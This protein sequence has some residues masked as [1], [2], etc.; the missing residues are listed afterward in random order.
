MN[1]NE[2]PQVAMCVCCRRRFTEAEISG[3]KGCPACG[4]A[5]VPADPREIATITLTHHEWRLLG[6]WAHKWGEQCAK[7]RNPVDGIVGEMRRQAPDL[8]P[9]TMG[10]EFAGVKKLYPSAEMFDGNGNKIAGELN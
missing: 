8:P 10:E 4:D 6:I 3:A 2:K 7:L 5:G 9:L 1:S